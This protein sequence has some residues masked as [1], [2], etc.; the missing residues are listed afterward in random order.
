[1]VDVIIPRKTVDLEH[2]PQVPPSVPHYLEI[3]EVQG[4]LAFPPSL[5]SLGHLWVLVALKDDN[6]NKIRGLE[7]GHW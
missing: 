2:C 6:K 7:P 5:H 3:Q 1:M 4:Y